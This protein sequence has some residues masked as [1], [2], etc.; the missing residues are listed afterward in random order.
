MDG[1]AQAE[2]VRRIV[3]LLPGLAGLVNRAS[4]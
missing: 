3:A 2:I 4:V 1:T